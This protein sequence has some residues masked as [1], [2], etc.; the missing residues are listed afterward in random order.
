MFVV[1]YKGK[2]H[3]VDVNLLIRRVNSSANDD[4]AIAAIREAEK[5]P[6]KDREEFLEFASA[7]YI[8]MYMDLTENELVQLVKRYPYVV[9]YRECPIKVWKMAVKFIPQLV[10]ELDNPCDE[11]AIE[12]IK[13]NVV[14]FEW[15]KNPSES[16]I[17]AA[18]ERFGPYIKRVEQTEELC[19]LAVKCSPMALAHV[20]DQTDKIIRIA[21]EENGS[22]IRFVKNQAPEYQLLAVKQC[23]NAIQYICN[24]TKTV[25]LYV[26]ENEYRLYNHINN[27]CASAPILFSPCVSVMNYL[28]TFNVCLLPPRVNNNTSFCRVQVDFVFF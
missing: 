23:L 7:K 10:Y 12:A 8:A 1:W 13:S 14:V 17:K 24:P 28:T 5:L 11:I 16:V 4:D 15:L 27:P 21:L 22:A 6:K 18:V 9:K 19:E 3:M 25:Q 2:L 26:V 20:K